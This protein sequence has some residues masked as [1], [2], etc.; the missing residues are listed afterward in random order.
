MVLIVVFEMFVFHQTIST[1]RDHN[2]IIITTTF[3]TVEFQGCLWGG[4]TNEYNINIYERRHN[5]IRSASDTLN[6][7]K[8]VGHG[9]IVVSSHL[10]IDYD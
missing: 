5:S 1:A 10:D 2:T 9:K 7:P 6:H 3:S 4:L 8:V